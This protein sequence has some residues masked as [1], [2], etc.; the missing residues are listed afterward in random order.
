M[1]QGL[2]F[3]ARL[4]IALALCLPMAAQADQKF[5]GATNRP[6]SDIISIPLEPSIAG[7]A[8]CRGLC[9]KN[10]ECN[11]WTMVASGIQGPKAMCWLKRGV[12]AAVP[13]KCCESGVIRRSV[14]PNM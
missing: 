4:L 11:S 13:D 7:A 5:E 6:G 12:P 1:P 9:I 3:A 8:I 14:E 10:D 2:V